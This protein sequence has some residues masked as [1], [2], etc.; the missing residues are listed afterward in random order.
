MRTMW[1]A[2]LVLSMGVTT[3]P[4]A[5]ADAPSGKAAIAAVEELEHARQHAMV[6]VDAEVLS[7]IFADDMTYIHSTGLAQ[8]RDDLMEMLSRGDIQYVAF[9]VESVSYHVYG[10]TVVGTGVQAIELTSSGKAF[11]SRSRYVVVYVPVQGQHRLV[12]YQSTTMP[13]IV[14]QETVGDRKAP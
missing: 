3:A 2:L 4:A 13:E 9:K 12:S 11:I 7:G 10:A 14:M 6:S 5:R 8:T 1:A